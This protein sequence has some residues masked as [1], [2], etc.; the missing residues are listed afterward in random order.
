M[1][2]SLY[3]IEDA[4]STL[5][6]AREELTAALAESP[7]AEESEETKA[8]LA[9]VEKTLTHYVGQEAA[10]VDSIQGWLKYAAH[11]AMAAREES[12]IMQARAQRLE[13]GIER[14]KGIVCDVMAARALKRLEGTAGRYISRRGNG[15]VQPLQVLPNV[16]PIEYMDATVAI[17]AHLVHA[18][19]D[20]VDR[21]GYSMRAIGQEPANARIRATLSDSCTGCG[22]LGKFPPGGAACGEC[23]GD[24]KRH[25]PGARLLDRGEHIECR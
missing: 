11:T 24:G 15:G 6:D 10:K 3:T 2:L 18:V 1:S 16:L 14:L 7:D 22:G 9:E 25:V 23:G 19:R 5:M 4:L 21:E 8:E 12:R 17:P 20:L 13:A